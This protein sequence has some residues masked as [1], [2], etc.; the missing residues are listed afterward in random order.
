[1]TVTPLLFPDAVGRIT[2]W[3]RLT[4]RAGRAAVATAGVDG[5][6]RLRTLAEP[7]YTDHLAHLPLITAFTAGGK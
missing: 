3:V 7:Q 4:L 2:D 1:M 5:T 6:P